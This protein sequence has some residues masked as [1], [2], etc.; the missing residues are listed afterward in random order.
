MKTKIYEIALFT[1][2]LTKPLDRVPRSSLTDLEKYLKENQNSP[3]QECSAITRTIDSTGKILS[4]TIYF[5]TVKIFLDR[6]YG[7][8]TMM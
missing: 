6:E 3:T 8:S 1:G 2:D 4:N 7:A 5:G